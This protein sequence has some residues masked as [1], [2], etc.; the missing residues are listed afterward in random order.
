MAVN[1]I[2]STLK[3]DGYAKAIRLRKAGV[4]IMDWCC[5]SKTRSILGTASHVTL[6]SVMSASNPNVRAQKKR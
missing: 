5:T 2:R 4:E 1:S 6:V 3:M